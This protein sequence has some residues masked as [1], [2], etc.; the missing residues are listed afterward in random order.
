MKRLLLLLFIPI[1]SFSQTFS[2]IKIYKGDGVYEKFPASLFQELEER[3]LDI[4]RIIPVD[5]IIIDTCE[6]KY[7]EVK[8]QECIE[9]WD[10]MTKVERFRL[11]VVLAYWNNLYVKKSTI[12]MGAAFMDFGGLMKKLKDEP[13]KSNI[14]LLE[15][16]LTEN[17]TYEEM[18]GWTCCKNFYN[19]LL[20]NLDLWSFIEQLPD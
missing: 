5:N 3:N 18:V 12:S 2:D 10:S 6:Y 11:G 8:L 4:F 9:D 16:Y 7:N 15:N 19:V 1:F 17:Y 13:H 20:E 14:E